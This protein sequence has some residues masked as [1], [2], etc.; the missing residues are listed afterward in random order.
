[1]RSTTG[2]RLE[3]R[4]RIGVHIDICTIERITGSIDRNHV[5]R[6]DCAQ[7]VDVD[8]RVRA[9]EADDVVLAVFGT[10]TVRAS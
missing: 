10:S 3:Q 9:F 2:S 6:A 5:R 8:V 4:N 7:T 1:M